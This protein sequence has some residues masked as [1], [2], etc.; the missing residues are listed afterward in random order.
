MDGFLS[1]QSLQL[2]G[3]FPFKLIFPSDFPPFDHM[4]HE[5]ENLRVQATRTL[6]KHMVHPHYTISHP[7]IPGIFRLYEV[8]IPKENPPTD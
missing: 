7:P 8:K 5:A 4:K 1:C 6:P 2:S 3:P